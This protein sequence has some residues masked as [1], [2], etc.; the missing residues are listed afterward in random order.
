M[1]GRG[2]ISSTCLFRTAWRCVVV[3]RAVGMSSSGSVGAP[4]VEEVSVP[5]DGGDGSGHGDRG[6]GRADGFN[7]VVERSAPTVA[8]RTSEPGDGRGDGPL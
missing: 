3:G 4:A 5:G 1:V 6:E 2:E 7:Q 8:Q